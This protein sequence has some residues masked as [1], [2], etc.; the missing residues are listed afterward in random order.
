MGFWAFIQGNK[1]VT[2]VRNG[3]FKKRTYCIPRTKMQQDLRNGCPV[4]IKKIGPVIFE[5]TINFLLHWASRHHDSAWP[6]GPHLRWVR[7]KRCLSLLRGSFCAKGRTVDR[8]KPEPNQPSRRENMDHFV[9]WSD[10]RTS[11]FRSA[12]TADSHTKSQL[13]LEKYLE[14][15]VF[16]W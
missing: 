2:G 6:R 14:F 5:P 7:V 8:N 3:R 10:I 9:T 13:S 4:C 11:D 16:L 15:V 12:E 1:W